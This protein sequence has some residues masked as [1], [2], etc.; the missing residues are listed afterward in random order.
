MEFVIVDIETTGG[1]PTQGSITEIAAIVSDGQKVLEKFHTLINPQRF[2]P[3]FITGLTG[4]NQ[5]MVESAPTFEEVSGE[6]YEFLKDRIFVAHNVNFDYSFLREAFKACGLDFNVPKLCTVRLSRKAFPGLGSYGLGRICEQLSIKISARHRA[7]GD[8]EATEVLFRKIYQN[9]SDIILQSLKKGKGESFL[10]P[11]ISQEKYQQIPEA[12]G[13]YFFHDKNGQVIY[14][15]KALNIKSRFKSHFSGNSQEK[16]QL[17]SEIHDI[18]WE[19]TGSEFLAY[20]LET[21]EI[22]RLWPK[23]NRAL[24]NQSSNWALFQYEDSQ[25]FIRFQVSKNTGKIPTLMEFDSHSEGWKYIMDQTELFELCPKLT[26]IQKTVQA[27]Y[28]HQIN[29]CHGACCGKEEVHEYN[30]RARQFIAS[31]QTEKGSV[32]I[33]EKGRSVQ[34]TCVLL[35]E[36]GILTAYGFITQEECLV[37]NEDI[38]QRLIKVKHIPETKYILR[39]FL[40]KIHYRNIIPV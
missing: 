16:F 21:M 15:G 19:L 12:T 1:N 33:K 26:G 36:N 7:Y 20:L 10:P 34:E 9:Q 13:I 35:F 22:K 23:Y 29:K 4:I 11:H 24:K 5:E 32:L 30:Q 27:C 17:K 3:N 6:L 40:P 28:D 8:A 25:G 38:L 37:H 39:A 2:I 14:V 31:I 18:S